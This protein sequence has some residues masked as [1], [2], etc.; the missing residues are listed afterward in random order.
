MK[1][2]RLYL[3]AVVA[4]ASFALASIR[5]WQHDRAE[6]QTVTLRFA[7]WQLEAGVRDA[8]D[9]VA[10][11]YMARNPG[12]RVVQMTI[13][14]RIYPAWLTTQLSGGTP[15][16]LVQL[17]RYASEDAG[18]EIL[19]RHFEP[20]TEHT[21]RPNPYNAGT[22]LEGV[23]WRSTF[24]DY[25]SGWTTWSEAL[26]EVYGVPTTIFSIRVYYNRELYRE[27]TGSDEPPLTL[28]AFLEVCA[29]VDRHAEATGQNLTP[30][31][32]SEFN[33][34]RLIETLFK[35]PTQRWRVAY[36]P[37][38]SHGLALA[39]RDEGLLQFATGQLSMADTPFRDGFALIREVGEQLGGTVLGMSREDAAMRFLQGRALMIISG[40]WDS[41]GLAAQASFPVDAFPLPMPSA[42]H[43]RFGA[44]I[45]GP[46][47]EAGYT[48]SGTLGVTRA[49]KHPGVAIDFLR[50]LTSLEGA[51]TF[52]RIS[53]WPSALT[54]AEIPSEMR[55]F[56]PQLD[57]YPEGWAPMLEG[58]DLRRGFNV[59]RHLLFN[60]NGG[61]EAFV[62]RYGPAAAEAA[63]GDL[64]RA[65]VDR[66]RG[67]RRLDAVL[68][69]SWALSDQ[70]PAAAR[71][72]SDL[73]ETQL[74][75][76]LRNRRIL[77][78]LAPP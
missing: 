6:V 50:Y 35:Y 7:H 67:Q 45:H 40:T 41:T 16:D 1:R 15:P 25:L 21:A 43:E 53:R 47:S 33:V 26:Q 29:R 58:A 10:A 48:G 28:E 65:L 76:D 30:I 60:P 44:L 51:A 56:A 64:R 54:D 17:G 55:A 73:A 23:P 74:L 36:D 37:F 57:G 77:S 14:D 13:P 8:F 42:D 20:L 63:Q 46:Q 32:G 2:L 9:Q 27:I 78:R 4:L 72:F 18:Y 68:V 71:R 31:A 38:R 39:S 52:S 19:A 49:S 11:D 61:T 59:N 69:A 12:V 70:D 24:L 66:T 5:L 22:T 75:N 3:V 62:E 34:M